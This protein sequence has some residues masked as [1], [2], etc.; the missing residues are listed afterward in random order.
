MQFNQVDYKAE[1]DARR[2]AVTAL[3][4]AFPHLVPVSDKNNSL[5]AAAKNVRIELARA[6]PGIKFSV[7][8]SRFAG[9]DS[10]RVK[11]TDGPTD[12]QVSAIAA[13][14]EAGDFDGMTDCYN[15]RKDKSWPEAFGD[16]KYV[17]TTRDYSPALVQIAIDYIW[18]HFCPE[19]AKITPDTYFSGDAYLVEVIKGGYPGDTNAQTQI[20][21]FAHKFDCV[22][23]EV[24][25]DYRA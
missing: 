17:Q 24:A 11:W 14:Y 10:L 25:E 9:G 13:Q 19:V 6:F 8:T 7:T 5:V 20:H 23:N 12:S 21:R 22:K 18:D 16:A 1:Q 15:Y 2:F 3:H 4:Q